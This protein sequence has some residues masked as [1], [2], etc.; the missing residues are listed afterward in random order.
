MVIV[1]CYSNRKVTNTMGNILAS[2][3]GFWAFCGTGISWM[4]S[5]QQSGAL[6]SVQQWNVLTALAKDLSSVLST[7]LVR[8][9]TACESWILLHGIWCPLL[10]SVGYYYNH[11]GK[12]TRYTHGKSYFFKK[13]IKVME[14][15]VIRFLYM[16]SLFSLDRGGGKQREW[17]R[18]ECNAIHSKKYWSWGP[19]PEIS[20]F[21][22][23]WINAVPQSCEHMA[24]PGVVLWN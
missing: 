15:M 13:K 11:M 20:V 8:L 7:P 22:V 4:V 16:K 2:I 3:P 10:F 9:T 19:I 1:F 12:T 5:R 21:S 24:K 14:E 18:R 17:G 23:K 6:E